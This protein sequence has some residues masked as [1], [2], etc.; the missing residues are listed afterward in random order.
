MCCII[1]VSREISTFICSHTHTHKHVHAFTPTEQD[2]ESSTPP[3]RLK[4]SMPGILPR[5]LRVTD[6]THTHMLF[7]F[8]E[9]NIRG[10]HERQWKTLFTARRITDIHIFPPFIQ[11]N[12]LRFQ[13][14]TFSVVS[15]LLKRWEA[16][17]YI[18]AFDFII[19]PLKPN[20]LNANEKKS[21]KRIR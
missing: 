17:E 10:R 15:A 11:T 8:K 12:S 16:R 4:A 21:F 20:F 9:Q 2:G 18:S 5:F 7:K 1:R 13:L 19:R 3:W 14:R 6:P